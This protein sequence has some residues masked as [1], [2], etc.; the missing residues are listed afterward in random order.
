MVFPAPHPAPLHCPRPPRGDGKTLAAGQQVERA[1]LRQVRQQFATADEAAQIERQRRPGAHR[2]DAALGV[3]HIRAAGHIAGGK[4]FGVRGALQ[5]RAG[6]DEA[7]RI[8]RQATAAQPLRRRGA[9]RH[10]RRVAGQARAAAE[11]HAV[12]PHLRAGV[13]E[14]GDLTPLQRSLHAGLHRR[15]M[16]GQRGGSACDQ[17]DAR[18]RRSD[19]AQAVLQGHRQLDTGRT[20]TDHHHVEHARLRQRQQGRPELREVLDRAHEQRMFARTGN[21]VAVHHRAGVQAQHVVGQR[22]AV[23]QRD[24]LVGRVDAGGGGLDEAG[25]GSRGER[26]QRDHAV[27]H[28]I[29][30]RHEAG[31][32]A[33]VHLARERRD[34]GDVRARHALPG[35]RFQHVDVGVA[36]AEQDEMLHP[37]AGRT[38]CVNGS[39]RNPSPCKLQ[40]HSS[41]T[42]ATCPTLLVW[43]LSES[44]PTAM[45]SSGGNSLT[46]SP[47]SRMKS[48]AMSR[49]SVDHWWPRSP[50][51]STT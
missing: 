4:Y 19:N 3:R 13:F 40:L 47:N 6:V 37:D 2:V 15:R 48:A 29:V 20:A 43:V 28:R 12:L 35:Q 7:L 26:R 8:Q 23:G 14:N 25:F 36:P 30:A 51:R 41:T 21:A 22:V 24:G 5:G 49:F 45:P 38:R 16:R 27:V 34:E 31:H 11:H 10:H 42:P 18:W 39:G 32:H 33:G 50:L 9:H 44:A 1:L 46:S 17:A